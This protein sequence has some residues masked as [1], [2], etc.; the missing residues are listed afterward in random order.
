MTRPTNDAATV[1]YA[2][3]ERV[4]LLP[5][6]RVAVLGYG[7]QGR[8]HAHNLRD[9]GIAV[10]VGLRPDSASVATARDEGFTVTD[11]ASAARWADVI[12]VLVP[13]TLAPGVF[14]ESVRP[15]L[16][17]GDALVFA[18]G[19]AVHHGLITAPGEVDVV[20]VAPKAPG[21]DVRESFERGR[22]CPALVAVAQDATGSGFSLA[23]DYA[24]ALGA[25]RAGA[26]ETTFAEETETDLFGEQAVLVGGVT[27]LIKT[28]FEVLVDAGYQP[29]SAYF[30]CLHELK[31]TVD[32]IQR[33]GLAAMT[34][35]ISD[36]AEYGGYSRGPRVIDAH[37][38]SSMEAV[39]ADIR[40]G[41]FAAEWVAE[42]Q[43]GRPHFR[44]ARSTAGA[45][46]IEAV[47]APLRRMTGGSATS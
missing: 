45:H 30:E 43:G 10:Q 36:T 39:L 44:T 11:T 29:E 25:T 13:D 6:R 1:H 24:D 42:D 32:L 33:H 14:T 17:P 23:L 5:D 15:N 47:G 16:D 40:S 7:S 18:H 19:F 20:M 35:H 46:A 4:P 9:S 38:R 21:R 41:G 34:D 22:G 37:V 27:E 26:L 2:D 8:A 3:E 31:L 28:A 12:V